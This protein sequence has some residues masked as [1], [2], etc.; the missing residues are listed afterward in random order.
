MGS[1]YGPWA[2]LMN[3]G[4]N[5]QLSTFWRRR[6]TMLAPT[7]QTS[8]TLSWRNL[9]CLV[10]AGTLM[11][12]LPTFRATTALAEEEKPLKTHEKLASGGVVAAVPTPTQI[13][14]KLRARRDSL[15]NLM[16]EASWE[17]YQNGKPSSWED[18]VIYRDNHG[19]IRIRCFY[20]SGPLASANKDHA[21]MNDETYNGKFTVNRHDDPTLDRL[22]NPLK[23]GDTTDPHNRY[24]CVLI[25]NGKW[26]PKHVGAESY[27]NPF[28]CMDETVISDLS[29]LLAVGKTVNVE[30]LKGQ[31]AV[32]E[33]G[34][35]L[36]DKDDPH[37]LKHRVLIDAD[38]GWLVTRNEQFFPDGRSARLSSCD[39]RRG[40][41]GWWLPTKGQFRNLWGK[42]V[43]DLDWRFKTGRVV[44][45]DSHFDEKIFQ[46][47]IEAFPLN[48]LTKSV[49]GIIVDPDGNPVEGVS[50]RADLHSG[51]ALL[52]A[53][54][55]QATG[56]DG[57]F[58]IDGLPNASIPIRAFIEPPSNSKDRR[59]F[60]VE[61]IFSVEVIAE[62]GQ[63][64][65]QIVLDPKRA[66]GRE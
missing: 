3:A 56:K 40:E 2:T 51:A 43:P 53:F 60:S 21:Q 57:R 19:H 62:A 46:P 15:D 11:I 23:S 47:E 28:R 65:L 32:Y 36:D 17:E 24:R 66:R 13:L 22:G 10:T 18:G 12:G 38:K 55:Q 26:P 42:E 35:E 52:M 59:I 39:Y 49:E 27:R 20:G 37:H 7:S 25:Y 64:D 33:L 61:G 5:P 14:E 48:E 50:V 44:V 9:L 8:S 45:N 29:G 54:S 34:Y 16:I 4:G 1:Q 6:L 58:I 63:K 41:D 30:S 31:S